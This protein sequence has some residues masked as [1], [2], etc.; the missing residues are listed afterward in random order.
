MPFPQLEYIHK[1][2]SQ[3]K[4]FLL[5][6]LLV[7]YFLMSMRTVTNSWILSNEASSYNKRKREETFACVSQDLIVGEELCAMTSPNPWPWVTL[8]PCLKCLPF[9]NLKTLCSFK[10]NQ[11]TLPPTKLYWTCN[12]VD[13]SSYEYYPLL[14]FSGSW[15]YVL[16][17]A[18]V[19]WVLKMCAGHWRCV[20]GIDAMRGI[21]MVCAGLWRCVLHTT[22][23]CWLPLMCFGALITYRVRSL[24]VSC[25]NFWVSHR[26]WKKIMKV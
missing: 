15:K 11:I 14:V 21:L 10:K 6:C 24:V 3:N 7:K 20:L 13:S 8:C 25:Y 4:T 18:N 9:V 2:M 23:V 19:C 26:S 5:K 1:N 17:S 16:T 12:V 22:D